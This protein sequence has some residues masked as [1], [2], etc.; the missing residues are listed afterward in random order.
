MLPK[1]FANSEKISLVDNNK[2]ITNG[3]DIAKVLNDFFSNRIKKLN[4]SKKKPYC[5][6]NQECQRS[7]VKSYI[8]ISY[9]S[10]LAIKRKTKSGPYLT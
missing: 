9:P 7:S 8:K 1:K 4:L 6:N 5:L 2:I 10:I 3:K